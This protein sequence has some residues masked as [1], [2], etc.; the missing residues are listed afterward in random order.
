MSAVGKITSRLIDL[1]T[2]VQARLL[3]SAIEDDEIIEMAGDQVH[4]Y[5]FSS[6]SPVLGQATVF[7]TIML[8]R[9]RVSG[10]TEYAKNYV[11]LHELGHKNR[12]PFF[13][14]ILYGTVIL[15]AL[16]GL[17]LIRSVQ[18]GRMV[19]KGNSVWPLALLLAVATAF[20]L[21]FLIANNIEELL[22]DLSAIRNVCR[23]KYLQAKEEIAEQRESTLR[24][25]LVVWLLY[26]KPNTVVKVHEL[27]GEKG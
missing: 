13:K 12:S 4:I 25:R 2:R 5:W 19:L 17:L 8:N 20:I 16:S 26:P 14:G 24:G 21:T 10:L 23:E 22:A 15:A 7:G 9:Q 3:Y 6:E 1:L 11:L 18:Y 27:V